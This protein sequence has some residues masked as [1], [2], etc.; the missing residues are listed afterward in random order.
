M[1]LQVQ[2]MLS[3]RWRIGARCGPSAGLV[4]AAGSDDRGVQVADLVGELAAGVALIADQ[5][6]SRRGGGTRARSFRAT[7]RS[8]RLGEARASALGVPSGAKIACSR[9]PQKKREWLAQ[10]P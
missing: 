10:Y 6:H 9:K 7:S 5:G 8:S 3:M 4:F 1:S 2:K